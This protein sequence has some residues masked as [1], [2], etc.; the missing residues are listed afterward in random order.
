MFAVICVNTYMGVSVYW[1]LRV[2]C[3][4]V[5]RVS[6]ISN[7]SNCKKLRVRSQ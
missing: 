5:W 4:F 7:Q 3:V 1:P 6:V 2:L